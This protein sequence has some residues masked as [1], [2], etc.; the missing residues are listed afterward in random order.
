[1][2][3][4]TCSYSRLILLESFPIRNTANLANANVVHLQSSP[5]L[6]HVSSPVAHAVSVS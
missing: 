3:V 5:S 1:M 6:W 4:A 2:R